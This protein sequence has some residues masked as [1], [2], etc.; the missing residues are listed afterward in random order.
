[1]A[2]TGSGITYH[3]WHGIGL[4]WQTPGMA[5]FRLGSHS[6]GLTLRYV[7]RYK[8]YRTSR[9]FCRFRH[10]RDCPADIPTVREW[11]NW[12]TRET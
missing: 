12:Q 4:P 8:S 3:F 2:L 5:H 6:Y 11:R 1:M 7:Q 10:R 9:V